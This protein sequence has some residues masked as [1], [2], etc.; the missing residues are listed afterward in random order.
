ME[1]PKD[2]DIKIEEKKWSKFWEKNGTYKFNPDLK[3]P[4]YSVD[5]PPPYISGK[6][7]IGHAF[8]Y[9]QQDFIVRFMRMHG[10][11]VFYPFGTDD[12]GLPTERFIEKTNNVKSR[13]MS[14][15]EFIDLCLKTLKKV[16]PECIQD[17]KDLAIS[18]DYDIYY[19]TIDK[20]S[21]KISQ[22]S[23]IQ[24]FKKGDAYQKDFPTIWCPECQ[25]SVAQAELEDKEQSSFFSTLKF[26]SEEKELPIATTR[27]EL[28]PACVAVFINP[29]DKRYKNLIGK[30][31]KVPLLN[32]EVP[33]LEDESAD[34]EKGTGIL[35]VCSY[36]DRSD[37]DAINRHKINPKIIL[38]KN[39]LFIEG[40]YKN[41]KIKEARKEILK[42]LEAQDLIL[43]QKQISHVVNTHDKCGTPIEFIPTKQWFI[44]ILD[45]KK[46]LIEQGNKI[47]WFP[48]F[49]KKRYENWVLGLEW[50]WSISRNRYF[51]VPI[52]AWECETCKEII[53]PEEKELPVDPLQTEKKCPKCGKKAKPE[54][55]V[56]DTWNTSSLTPQ[57]AIELPDAKKKIKIPVSLRPQGHDIIRTWAF[58]TIVKSF[59]HNNSIP[60]KDIV[61][62]GNV[63]LGGE[64]M[65]KSKGNTVNPQEVMEKYGADAVRFW[66]ASS[67]LGEDF[68]YEEKD[69]ITGKKTITKLWNAA[70]FSMMHLV[71][72]NPEKF[73]TKNLEQIDRWILSKLNKIV[74]E[75]T[76]YFEKYEYSRTK[77][78]V[79]NFF[80]HDFCDN[81]LEIIKDR[82]Y[83]P[84]KRGESGKLSA[85]FTLYHTLLTIIKLM[86]PIMPHITESL[87]QNY[88][89][90]HEKSDSIHIS[91][92][93]KT[94][95]KLIDEKADKIGEFFVSAL[96]DARKA[97]AEKQVSMKAPIKHMSL[98]GKISEP[99][100]KK[101]KDD[102]VAV[103]NIG[104]IEFDQINEK[105]KIDFECIIDI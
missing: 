39:G 1:L 21:Q 97:K 47:N 104:K 100:F 37:V 17:F 25:T 71:D 56:F 90:I 36:G 27:P 102:L 42:D 44:K 98:K 105:S 77:S 85:Q 66:A 43:E 30:K 33:I 87:Y 96:N 89:K 63:S 22:R 76:E 64:K 4:I 19:S 40:P 15:A 2:Y 79:E 67:K 68:D 61:I 7:H 84:D 23:F 95:K 88:F 72:F 70:K 14:R 81:Y 31:A 48:Q 11:N 74:K 62:S 9:S 8:S 75:S 59:Y 24:L 54:D 86:A 3:K 6:M 103:L 12:N 10:F 28:L 93:P 65:S 50:D 55:M 13:N 94:E 57:L 49:M 60:W 18:S 69:V 32:F 92:W 82:V 80:W 35:M 26:E 78:L 45:K 91:E 38:D 73:D 34:P 53:I 20:H 83:N 99:E 46:E 29:E 58:Y 101:I 52:P 5:T 41:M 51:G 16:T